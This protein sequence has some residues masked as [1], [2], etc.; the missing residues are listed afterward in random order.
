MYIRAL[1]SKEL[2]SQMLV[3]K[4][5]LSEGSP[6]AHSNKYYSNQEKDYFFPQRIK[7]FSSNELD[8]P[9]SD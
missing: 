7:H 1:N 9:M 3:D 5:S 2:V 4:P 8:F 6:F